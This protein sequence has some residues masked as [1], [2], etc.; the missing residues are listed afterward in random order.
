MKLATLCYVQRAGKTLMLERVKKAN[1]IHQGKW[2]GLGGKLE[3]GEMP[4]E[5][6]TREVLEESGLSIRSP[7]LRGLLTFP[8]FKDGED[9]YVYLYTADDFDGELIESPE[10]NL[11]WIDDA[12]VLNLPL[13]EGDSYFIP[14]LR[15]LRFF[16]ARFSYRD[17]KLLSHKV[18]FHENLD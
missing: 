5:C 14:W 16:S 18:I 4:E 3:P 7:R 6:V 9:W 13:W 15:D 8:E 12:D 10:G 17:G 11:A 1:D 2:N